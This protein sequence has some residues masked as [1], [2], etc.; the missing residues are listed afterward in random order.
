MFKPDLTQLP[1]P[2]MTLCQ[3]IQQLNGKA[4]LVGG[5]VRDLMLG[6]RPK[7]YDI[8]VFGLEMPVVETA[9]NTLGRTELVGQQF[10][11]LKLWMGRFEFDIA[12]P[13]SEIK[14]GS[15]HKGFDVTPDPFL[16]EQ[17]ATLRRDFSINAM[18]FDPLHNRLID[19]HH[20]IK[21][22][23]NKILRHI[24][25]A[26]S[27]DPLRPLR[28]IQF[29]ARFQLKLHPQTADLCRSLIDESSSL[30]K[31]RIWA[32][33]QKWSHAPYPSHGLKA[34]QESGWLSLYPALEAMPECPQSPYWHPEGDVWSH[35]LQ[36]CDQAAS[37]A[38][39]YQ[40]DDKTTEILVLAALCH[41]VGKPECTTID[42]S[43]NIRSPGHSQSGVPITMQFLDQIGVPR[44]LAPYISSLV[45]E[46][47]T[48]IHGEPTARAVRRLSHRLEPANIELWEMLVE[49]D[50][51]GRAPAPPSRPAL[52]WLQLAQELQHH[53][54]KPHAIL[55]GKMLL[56]LGMVP[57]PEMGET[58]QK[59][60]HAQLDGLFDD[61]KSAI[62]WF[63]EE[64]Q[65]IN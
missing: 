47:I 12:L 48:H 40:L 18:M 46:H 5:S 43:G 55:N 14:S 61:E 59:A 29:A 39:H 1:A 9:L 36:V 10:G 19:H 27:E 24:S 22:L 62:R 49:A 52:P 17:K 2:L 51:S 60:Y 63:S 11:V 38:T 6:Q 31:E 64:Q 50:A 37:V 8:E 57:G 3:H 33:W 25:P 54:Q 7:D 45:A 21:D 13:R 15:G 23:N 35:T 34:L 20:G 30:P 28:A 65:A 44:R 16:S 56:S 4:W 53:Q 42:Q 58:L 26:F 41:D 32:E